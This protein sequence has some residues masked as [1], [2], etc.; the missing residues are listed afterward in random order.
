LPPWNGNGL[1]GTGL[2]RKLPPCGIGDIDGST[3]ND[4]E[5][6]KPEIPLYIG[7]VIGGRGRRGF[8]PIIGLNESPIPGRGPRII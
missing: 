7:D 6:E 8:M 1:L 2:P 3:D 5:F 4:G